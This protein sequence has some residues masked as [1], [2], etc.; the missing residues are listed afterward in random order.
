M[1][2]G[3]IKMSSELWND[4]Y[5]RK[6]ILKFIKVIK[7]EPDLLVNGFIIRC[8]SKHFPKEVMEGEI[9]PQYDLTFKVEGRSK[10]FGFNRKQ[11]ILLDEVSLIDGKQ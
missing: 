5:I 11:R 8:E 7:V 4:R 9:L 10:I 2:Q 1:N 3:I 6:S